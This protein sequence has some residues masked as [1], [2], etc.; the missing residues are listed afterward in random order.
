MR[1]YAKTL[2][3]YCIDLVPL[4]VLKFYSQAGYLRI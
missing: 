4:L 3:G 2:I 1:V